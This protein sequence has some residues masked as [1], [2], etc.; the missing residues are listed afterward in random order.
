MVFNSCVSRVLER[1]MKVIKDIFPESL[2]QEIGDHTYRLLKGIS[3]TDEERQTPSWTNFQWQDKI[4]QDT[5][6]VIC[7]SMPVSLRRKVVPLLKASNLFEDETEESLLEKMHLMM[8]VWTKGSWIN[9]HND[10]HSKQ[11]ITVY[12]NREWNYN[13]GGLF[14]WREP[15]TQELKITEPLFNTLVYNEGAI[16]HGTTPVTSSDQLRITLQGFV[17]KPEFAG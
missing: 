6:P 4:R 5:A 9:W 12:L 1:L 3:L 2:C 10:G 15:T 8:Y 7:Y 11:A 13:D 17:V 14:V 16:D